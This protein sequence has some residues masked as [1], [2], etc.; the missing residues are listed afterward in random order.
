MVTS[1]HSWQSFP[2]R[3]SAKRLLQACVPQSAIPEFNP[4]HFAHTSTP[5]TEKFLI[6]GARWV[7][8]SPGRTLA[9]K[10]YVMI[11]KSLL[12]FVARRYSGTNV[13][14]NRVHLLCEQIFA[15]SRTRS[16]AGPRANKASKSGP[17][18]SC[19]PEQHLLFEFDVLGLNSNH[20]NP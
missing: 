6:R 14:A 18:P 3:D 2:L 20:L 9:F 19:A 17:N 10:L 4:C 8:D 5:L 11:C 1:R 15:P 7:G 13:R 16:L 12:E